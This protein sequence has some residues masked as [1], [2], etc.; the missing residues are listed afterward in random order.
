MKLFL[1]F[2]LISF[3]FGLVSQGKQVRNGYWAATIIAVMATALYFVFTADF[4]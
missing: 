1:A 3:S 4:I 2:L